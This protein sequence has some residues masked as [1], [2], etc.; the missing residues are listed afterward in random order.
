M[1]TQLRIDDSE[2]ETATKC[3][4]ADAEPFRSINASEVPRGNDACCLSVTWISNS[5]QIQKVSVGCKTNNIFVHITKFLLILKS[6]C[7]HGMQA[8]VGLALSIA[9]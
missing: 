4:D 3:R 7:F 9:A 6:Y 1:Q 2:A 8:D 5:G